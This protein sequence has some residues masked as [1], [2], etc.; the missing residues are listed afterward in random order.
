MHHIN[1]CFASL[2][3]YDIST[4]NEND[5]AIILIIL[6]YICST[7]R[8]SLY[9]T[10][11]ALSVGARMTK[12]IVALWSRPN[13]IHVRNGSLLNLYRPVSMTALGLI[14]SHYYAF[15]GNYGFLK[16]NGYF[17]LIYIVFIYIVYHSSPLTTLKKY[18]RI[19]K[20]FNEEPEYAP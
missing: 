2:N 19:D 15:K 8:T 18:N 11:T 14:W 7:R 3:H 6:P 12:L 17:E 9:S 13:K 1:V 20:V 10:F 4:V 16:S 5:E